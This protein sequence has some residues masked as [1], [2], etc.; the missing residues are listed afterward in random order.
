METNEKRGQ[1]KACPHLCERGN[2]KW[3]FDWGSLIGYKSKRQAAK[4]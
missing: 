4:L 1:L 3:R 2:A